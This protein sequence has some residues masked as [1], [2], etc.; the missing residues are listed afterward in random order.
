MTVTT[1]RLVEVHE[2][3]GMPLVLMLMLDASFGINKDGY[4]GIVQADGDPFDTVPTGNARYPNEMRADQ[5]L[6]GR[7]TVSATSVLVNLS[8]EWRAGGEVVVVLRNVRSPPF[9][10]PWIKDLLAVLHI[11]PIR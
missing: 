6:S 9:L 8:N 3:Y 7:V 4:S 11:V 2:R 10:G 1:T 5:A